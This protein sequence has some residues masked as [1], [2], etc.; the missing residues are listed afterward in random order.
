MRLVAHRGFAGVYPEN[1]LRALAGASPHAD[2]VEID[3]R[4]CG[5]GELVVIHDETV[6]R[7][8]GGTGRVADHSLSDLR[9]LDVRGSGEGVPTLQAAL[10]AI[11]PEVGVNVELKER[12]TAADALSLTHRTDSPVTISSFDPAILARVRET[13]PR[14]SRALVLE[15]DPP[16]GL[17]RARELGCTSVNP[18]VGLC[19]EPLVN[20]AHRAGMEVNAWTVEDPTTGRHLAGLGVDGAIADRWGVTPGADPPSDGPG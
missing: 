1:T 14:V 16:A 19:D 4:R 15:T 8:T 7:V 17:S 6:D 3:V 18:A 20:S 11:P 13:A 5:S 2:A 12:G 9:G 10:A